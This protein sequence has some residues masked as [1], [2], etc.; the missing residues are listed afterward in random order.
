MDQSL[1]YRELSAELP[2]GVEPGQD[3]LV[4]ELDGS[5]IG[6]FQ[7]TPGPISAPRRRSVETGGGA[8]TRRSG[9][10]VYLDRKL[11]GCRDLHRFRAS[12]EAKAAC[13]HLI[14]CSCKMKLIE[15]VFR[16]AGVRR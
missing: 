5:L 3:G 4:I 2:D 11:Q 9:E 15:G 10:A 13:K 6:K 8:L 1:D 14:I 7:K 12:P 16:D